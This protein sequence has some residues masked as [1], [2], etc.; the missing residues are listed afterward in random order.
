MRKLV[1]ALLLVLLIP[2]ALIGY[3]VSTEQGLRWL[4]AGAARFAP[5]ELSVDKLDGRLAG[6]LEMRGI[7]YANAGATTNID[8]VSLD[9][10]AAALLEKNLVIDKLHIDGVRLTLAPAPDEEPT[11]LP[12]INLPVEINLKDARISN[13]T[14]QPAE[15]APPFIVDE[16]LLEAKYV[17]DRLYI[18]ALRVDAPLFQAKAEGTLQ[19]RGDYPVNLQIAWTVSPPNFTPVSGGGTLSGKLEEQLVLAQNVTSPFRA[20]LDARLAD[21]W[22]NA[23]WNARLQVQE[24]KIQD[25]NSDWPAALASAQIT[26]Q[27]KLDDFSAQGTLDVSSAEFG[28]LQGNFALRG[29][30]QQIVLNSLAVN[31][32]GSD[33]QLSA[34]GKLALNTES[35]R[36][37]ASAA[38]QSLTWPLT[39]EGQFSSPQGELKIQGTLDN[40]QLHVTTLIAGQD[41]PQG[42]WTAE[43]SGNTDSLK[44]ITLQG[45]ML[46]GELKLA[47]KVSWQPR[48]AWELNLQGQEI[49]P[50]VAWPAFP[51]KLSIAANSTGNIGADGLVHAQA[52]IERVAGLLQENP[53]EAQAL[54]HI[55]GDHYRIPKLELASGPARLSAQAELNGPAPLRIT[56]NAQWKS[57]VW[58]LSGDPLVSSPTGSL[59]AR[60]TLDNYQLHLE[61][62]IAGT[63]IPAG[64]WQADALGNQESLALTAL[65]GATLDGT[66]TASGQVAWSPL[67][68]WQLTLE[69][70]NLNPGTTW[71]E[72]PGKLAIAART[73]GNV[74]ASGL[75][76]A[77]A[78]IERLS[79]VLRGYPVSATTQVEIDAGNYVIPALE[80]NS[81]SA[82]LTA[83]GA[84]QESWDLQWQLNVADLQTVLAGGSG[85]VKSQGKVSGP[86][87][88]PQVASSITA[89]ALAYQDY[90]IAALNANADLDL[91]GNSSSKLTAEASGIKIG[92]QKIQRLTLQGSG[93]PDRH[94]LTVM[95]KTPTEN[96]DMVLSGTWAEPAWEGQLRTAQLQ[97]AKFGQWQLAD[98]VPLRASETAATLGQLCLVANTK[99]GRV[100]AQGDWQQTGEMGGKLSLQDIPLALSEQFLPETV[101]I[102]GTLQGEAAVRL[103]QTGTV[104]GQATVNLAPGAIGYFLEGGERATVKHSGGRLTATA[105]PQGARGEFQLAL[106]DAGNVEGS[107]SLPQFNVENVAPAEQTI[108]G[109][110]QARFDDL[111]L[112]AP[113]VP[114]LDAVEGLIDV[115]LTIAGNLAQPQI[116]GNAAFKNGALS[117]PDAGIR[118]HDITLQATSNGSQVLQISGGARSGEGQIQVSGQLALSPDEGFPASLRITGERFEAMAIPA[119]RI[120]VSPELAVQTTL[121]RIEV[122]GEIL[123]PEAT[124]EPRDLGDPGVV[125][126]SQDVVI[127]NA[128]KEGAT[129]KPAEQNETLAITARVRIILGDDVHVEAFGFN[130]GLEGNVLVVDEPQSVTTGSGELTVVEGEYKAYGQDLTIETGRIIFGGPIENPGLDVRAI[131]EVDEVTAGVTVRGTVKQPEL[132][133]FSDPSMDDANVLSYLLLGR[134]LDQASGNEGNVLATA[135]ASLG[136][137]GGNL[138]ASRIGSKFGL[139]EVAI[140]SES[141]LEDAS[142]LLGKYL[143]PRLYIQYG[144]GLFNA[145]SIVR[146]RYELTKRFSIQT[147]TGSESGADILYSIER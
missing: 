136:L 95:A 116:S 145:A 126:V 21:A 32:P 25:L 57:L 55:D 123:V 30:E 142:L 138:L 78:D 110:L 119:A 46:D 132:T 50:G 112:I 61:T 109:K 92:A 63:N 81:G 15:D 51:G 104:T 35:M 29:S 73:T 114:A 111:G 103:S 101:D 99:N 130:G 75:M 17:D 5:G 122:T 121:N 129:G 82:R 66:L 65:Q 76:H 36:M 102:S 20:R 120:L 6:P 72:Y 3:L 86:R 139:E 94:Q 64:H 133:L 31:L 80:F 18:D 12:D 47:G 40:Y 96:L 134:P 141:G 124:I 9:W 22:M 83:S 68:T 105:T 118:V 39:G 69:G 140:E 7:R 97:S 146:I 42:H 70:Q 11:P 58:P 71:P 43:A 106:I 59:V 113:F 23:S 37:Q 62:D 79:G 85:S 33:A 1:I 45:D 127:V 89:Q 28:P 60:G 147:E 125:T 4:V 54:I 135:A 13:I 90:K 128:Q 100:C 87:A 107:V 117:V 8:K 131:R 143:S 144:V 26:S 19:P 34:Q 137:K 108:S 53:V 27:G 115:D 14:I 24:F 38:W 88:T 2:I 91:L 16:A 49:N 98:P 48:L 93:N 84:I 52:N 10:R 77:T 41:I 56:A 67:L 74:D 44:L